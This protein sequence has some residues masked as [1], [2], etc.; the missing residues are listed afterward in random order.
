MNEEALDAKFMANWNIEVYVSLG[1]PPGLRRI[2]VGVYGWH[3]P[4]Q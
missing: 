3:V 2:R 4:Q 1:P